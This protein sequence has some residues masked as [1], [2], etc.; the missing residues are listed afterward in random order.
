MNT[1]SFNEQETAKIRETVELYLFVKEL[2]IYNEIIDPDS[3]T[4]PQII[5]ELKNAYDH[6]NR[7]LAEKLEITENRGDEYS[8]NTLDKA[9]GHIYRACY[10]A[11]DWL[12]INITQDVKEDLRSFSHEA[13]RE[14]IPTY[15]KEIRPALPRYERRITALRTEKD[16]AS[17]ND[18][19]LSEYTQIVK[20]LSDIRQKIKDSVDALAEYDSKK[21]KEKRLLDLRNIGVGV[22]IGLIIAAVSWILTS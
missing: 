6:F 22:I 9:L 10:D 11:L 19:A 1:I 2:L 20:D 13:I 14:V 12:S 17:I 3:Y 8:I 15:Y 21:N 4:F 5:N 18:D 7:V 16:I